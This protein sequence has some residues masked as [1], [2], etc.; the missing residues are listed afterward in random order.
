MNEPKVNQGA[1]STA[2]LQSDDGRTQADAAA[3][4]LEIRSLSERVATFI[5]FA[6]SSMSCALVEVSPIAV[7]NALMSRSSRSKRSPL[8]SSAVVDVRIAFDTWSIS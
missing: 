5:A 6:R 3:S 4:V 7:V 8:A 1:S 2:D